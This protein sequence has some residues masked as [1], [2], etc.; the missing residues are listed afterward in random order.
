MAST[1]AATANNE[2]ISFNNLQNG[3]DTGVL[4]QKQLFL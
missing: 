2:T 4:S 1:W 3:V